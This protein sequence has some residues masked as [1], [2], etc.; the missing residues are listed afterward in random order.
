MRHT[1][2]LGL[3]KP[4]PLLP[5]GMVFP[6]LLSPLVPPAGL[7]HRLT[8]RLTT[9]RARAVPLPAIAVRAH[10]HLASASV[11]AQQSSVV[12]GPAASPTE[13]RA[14]CE[15]GSKALYYS[16]AGLVPRGG[17]GL[18]F[19]HHLGP[20]PVFFS[21]ADYRPARSP[22]RLPWSPTPDNDRSRPLNDNYN[23]AP[24]IRRCRRAHDRSIRFPTSI[25][26]AIQ[27]HQT[28]G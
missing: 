15:S 6:A 20:L 12:R 1:S 13:R 4:V 21:T 24:H 22:L 8:P 14:R 17:S 26:D 27:L 10:H 18:G 25:D 28:A 7:P 23:C 19:L 16:P 9:A 2:L 5:P 11:A 3:P